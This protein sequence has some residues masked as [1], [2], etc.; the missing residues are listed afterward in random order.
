MK[1]ILLL[2]LTLI[3]TSITLVVVFL[4]I[5]NLRYQIR[6]QEL[7]LKYQ[8]PYGLKFDF[9]G[10]DVSRENYGLVVVDSNDG[11]EL[12]SGK[13]TRSNHYIDRITDCYVINDSLI[14]RLIVN[15]GIVEYVLIDKSRWLE[16]IDNVE[17]LNLKGESVRHIILDENLVRWLKFNNEQ[18]LGVYVF[19]SILIILLS[20]TSILWYKFIG[21]IRRARRD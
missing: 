16:N 21:D 19:I 12:Y 3:V 10:Y 7:V 6:K 8:L 1:K 11:L 14:F 9:W 20:V 4:G 5:D 17:Y 13:S 15:G 18:S 2:I